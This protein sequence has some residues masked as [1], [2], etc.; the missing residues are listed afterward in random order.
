MKK[1]KVAILLMMAVS[2]LAGCKKKVEETEPVTESAVIETEIGQIETVETDSID[3]EHSYL[4]GEKTDTS[5][6]RQRPVAIML[7]NIINAC[8]QAGIEKAGVVY[9]VPVEGSLTRLMGIFEDYEELEKIGSIRSCRDYFVRYAL[10]F[11]A[12]YVHFGQAV[13][14]F[15]LL[16]S[17]KVDNISGLQSQPQAGTIEGYAGEDIFYRTSDRPSPHNVYTSYEQIQTAIERK[18]YS[19]DYETDYEGH[20]KFA[21]DG[22][23]ITYTD[24]NATKIT[25]GYLVNKPWFEYDSA[26]GLYSRFQYEDEQIDQLTEEQLTYTNI[27]FQVS[28]WENYDEN[29]YLNIDTESGGEAM[30]FSQGTY[31]KGTWK[32]AD[33]DAPARYYDASGE[34]ITLNQGKT[35]VCIILDTYKDNIVIE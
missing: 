5:I 19:T 14:A 11:D 15:D 32:K 9:E 33:E 27:I 31:Q 1:V 23:K 20:Y 24:G 29:G 10:E 25:P 30:I 16:N 7:N 13:Y 26:T 3:N 22:E 8:P 17:E 12:M 28:E 21:A 2:L 35:W 18:G 34:E 4:T 6:S